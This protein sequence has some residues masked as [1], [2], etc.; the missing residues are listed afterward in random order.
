MIHRVW[1]VIRWQALVK[2]LLLLVDWFF[3]C[4]ITC[5]SFAVS[6]YFS[7][8]NIDMTI[9]GFNLQHDVLFHCT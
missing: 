4:G 5:R 1:D 8:P 3:F 6:V 7:E 9:A 2:F